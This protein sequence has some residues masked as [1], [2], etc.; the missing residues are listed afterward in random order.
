MTDNDTA[1]VPPPP[2][3]YPPLAALRRSRSDRHIAGVSGGLGRYAGVDPLIFR[4]LFVVLLVFGGSGLLLYGLGWLLIPADGETESEG[5]RLLRGRT[6]GSMVATVVAGIVVLVLGLVFIGAVVDTG[7]G[8]GGLGVL[9]VVG[10][11]VALLLRHGQPP[12]AGPDVG[13]PGAVP[14]GPQPVTS[15]SPES[16]PSQRPA[17]LAG[18]AGP[19][20][21]GQ[22]AGTAYATPTT[23]YAPSG[24]AYPPATGVAISPGPP[25]PRERS[26]L[27]RITVSVALIAVGVM[28]AWNTVS[29]NDF[30]AVAILGTALA[31]VGGGL[32]V[33][34]VLGRSRGL[35]FLGVLLALATSISAIN[36][37]RDVGGGVGERTWSPTS[38]VAAERPF[39]LGVG[40]ARLDLGAL[41]PG[42]DVDIDV[43]LGIGS[44]TIS[45]PSDAVVL[46]DGRVGA[47]TMELLD[48]PSLDGTNLDA[49][50]TSG[51]AVGSADATRITID[52]SVG[53]GELR[54]TR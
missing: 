28:M 1:T 10:V 53:L 14:Y 36:V 46:V 51:T 37:S 12:G 2:R 24:P 13:P 50:A 16:P 19:A 6:S 32:L 3:P 22:S 26:A 39:R 18:P 8:L 52:A 7:P 47:G 34:S 21:Y 48:Q 5:Q 9:V 17:G 11:I 45:V 27:G 15:Q 43:R 49:T 35:I 33:G 41:P 54:V 20:D 23:G 40:D 4:I 25:P 30:R 42:S 44:L 31:V 29:D 38:V